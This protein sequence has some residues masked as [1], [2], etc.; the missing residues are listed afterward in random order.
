VRTAAHLANQ[1]LLLHLAPELTQ[2][3]LE[4]LRILDDYLQVSITP[5]FFV[6]LRCR[7]TRTTLGLDNR[8]QA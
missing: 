2:R 1:A 7:R 6:V 5:F 8:C 4:L 3:L